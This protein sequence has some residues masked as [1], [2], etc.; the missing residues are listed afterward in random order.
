[1][2]NCN[3]FTRR[4]FV[5]TAGLGAI[6]AGTA[7][8]ATACQGEVKQENKTKS[9]KKISYKSNG[10]PIEAKINLDTQEVEINPDV[11]VRYSACLGCYAS[12]GN[13][14]KIDAKTN[15]ILSVG[16]NPYNP[17]C[18]LPKLKFE[19]SLT[20]AYLANSFANQKGNL[21]RG[22]VCARGNSTFNAYKD[23]KRILKP[24]KRA[25]KRGEG[26]WKTISWDQLIDEVV[27]GGKLFSDIGEDQVI[28]GF[29]DVYDT[30]TLIDENSPEYGPK[31]NQLVMLGMRGDGR[32]N[33]PYLFGAAFG[34]VNFYS[35][36]SSCGVAASAPIFT[37]NSMWNRLDVPET[38]YALWL[39]TFPGANGK[40]FQL[41]AK[42]VEKRLKDGIHMDV[43]DPVNV[44]GAVTSKEKNITWHP[45]KPSTNGA[46]VLGM[47][48]WIIDNKKYSEEYVTFPNYQAADEKG[49]GSYSNF[50]HLVICDENHPNNRKFLRTEDLG[51]EGV[52]P[53]E[54]E[55]VQNYV[56]LDAQT[57]EPVQF[58]KTKKAVLDFTGELKGSDG[59]P[60]KVRTAFSLVKESAQSHSVEEYEEICQC[61]K[62]LIEKLATEW[63]SHGPKV[64]L[65][66]VG[67]TG[68]ANGISSAW[69][70]YILGA[71]VGNYQMIG[72]SVPTS[73]TYDAWMSPRYVLFDIPDAPENSA[74]IDISRGGL[75]WQDTSEYKK[76]LESGEENPQPKLPWY[77]Y[78][79]GADNQALISLINKYPYQGKIVMS[80]M[81]NALQACPGAMREE[82]YARLADPEVIPLHITCDCFMGEHATFSDYIVPDTTPYE[83]F[84]VI[85]QE[86]FWHG[87]GSSVRWPVSEP[88]TEKLPD[89]RHMGYEAFMNDVAKAIGMPFFGRED[90]L[91]SLDGKGHPHFSDADYYLKSIANLAYDEKPVDDITDEEIKAQGLDKLPEEWKKCVSEE[92]WPKVLKVL[93]RGGRFDETKDAIDGTRTVMR[94]EFKVNVYSELRALQ[95]NSFTGEYASGCIDWE[96]ELLADGTPLRD[97]FSESDYPYTSVQYKPKFR[98]ISMLSN[99]PFMQTLAHSNYF[100][101]NSEDAQ[102]LGVKSGDSL[103]VSNPTGDKMEGQALV[104]EGIARKVFA[105]PF[106]YGH[107]AYGAKGYEI[108]GQA[109]EGDEKISKGIHLATMLDPQVSKDGIIYPY[110]EYELGS[111]ARSGGAFKIEKA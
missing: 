26:K 55:E 66:N 28:E 98:S 77:S 36:G 73:W 75:N 46:L 13:R 2:E 92:E 37:E 12:C 41:I 70:E 56:V 84:G 20:E 97:K 111:P 22:T 49:W 44:G 71:L 45:I 89:G 108:D 7:L 105:V 5:K 38:E 15:E 35:H 31:S 76:R 9:N 78:T 101:I 99:S 6:L 50:T 10:K 110:S 85:T 23:K 86:G 69:A 34:S 74:Q 95:R 87:R 17:N 48:R 65:A 30:K 42:N 81:C 102:E 106:G 83:S 64:G 11:Y 32:S 25:G 62:G 100:E 107:I 80:W 60:I 88:K 1:M 16:G 58:S 109:I 52:A 59:K 39:G 103:I 96:P 8:S 63:T 53:A 4:S 57:N 27:N 43:I 24:L 3:S 104:R 47:V 82:V 90:G 79:R 18:A 61:E 94:M 54:G 14:T 29:K 68:S 67:G 51:I 33:Y 93:S 21:L 40:S 91:K 72:G 19:D